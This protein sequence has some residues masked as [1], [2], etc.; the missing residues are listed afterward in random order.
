M[1]VTSSLSFLLCIS[2]VVI[3]VVDARAN[4]FGLNKRPAATRRFVDSKE[5]FDFAATQ[6]SHR[7]FNSAATKRYD[8]AVHQQRRSLQ[9]VSELEL[10]EYATR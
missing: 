8:F 7:V 5:V 4:G 9:Y 2:S 3:P 6:E 10:C 1:K